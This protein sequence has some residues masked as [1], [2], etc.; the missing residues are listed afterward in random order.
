MDGLVGNIFQVVNGLVGMISKMVL[1]KDGLV[2]MDLH[3][4]AYG[5]KRITG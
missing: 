2:M 5:T 3:T 4:F 1:E